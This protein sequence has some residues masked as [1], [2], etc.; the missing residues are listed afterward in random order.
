MVY[1][2]LAA[3]R[4]RSERGDSDLGESE[5]AGVPLTREWREQYSGEKYVEVGGRQPEE[6]QVPSSL[7]TIP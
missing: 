5:Q 3:G 7:L 1:W 2:I 6:L 4:C